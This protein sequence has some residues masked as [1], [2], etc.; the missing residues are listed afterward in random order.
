MTVVAA[1]QPQDLQLLAN[2][3][4]S[5]QN[6]EPQEEEETEIKEEPIVK[7][8]IKEEVNEVK[9]LSFLCMLGIL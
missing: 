2:S 1:I 9:F 3:G 5:I 4:L 7:Q 6:C 8:E